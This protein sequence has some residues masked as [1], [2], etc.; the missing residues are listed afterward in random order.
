MLQ[1][2]SS[3]PVCP[4]LNSSQQLSVV[5]WSLCH[6]SSAGATAHAGSLP[7]LSLASLTSGGGF[8]FLITLNLGGSDSGLLS[9][10]SGRNDVAGHAYGEKTQVS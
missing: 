10:E 6:A 3:Q 4:S 8:D 1:M 2:E 7:S 9:L 5:F